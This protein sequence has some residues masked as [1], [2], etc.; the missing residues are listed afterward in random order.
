MIT[1]IEVKNFKA[2]IHETIPL[3][4]LNLL[5]GINGLGKSTIIQ[6]LLLL[7]Q[8]FN[9]GLI[10]NKGILLNGD[11]I[12]LGRANDILNIHSDEKQLSFKIEFDGNITADFIFNYEQDNDFLALSEKI[13]DP[14]PFID[15]ALF[16]PSF[17]YLSAERISPKSAYSTSLFEVDQNRGLGIHGEYTPHFLAQKQREKVS[18]RFLLHPNAN[19]DD[20]LT[21]VIFWAKEIA[22]GISLSAS[23]LPQVEASRIAYQ[24]EQGTSMTPEFSPANI[25]FGVTY[26]LPVLTSILSSRSGDL[27]I[28]ENPESHLHPS[29]QS[30]LGELFFRAALSGVQI[31]VETHS[32]HFLNGVRLA[33]KRA[34]SHSDLINILFFQRS[35]KADKHS[36][37]I[38][39][40][41]ID[42]SGNIESWPDGF[43]DQSLN[44]LNL[45]LGL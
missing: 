16:T 28:I 13:K 44:D 9:K 23:Y 33:V 39:Y 35:K 8:S 4:Q 24:Y 6:I 40:P 41:K 38:V 37:E 20:L 42:N 5:T 26:V 11:L 32:D 34:E 45:L 22:P 29:G 36:T 21:Q 2:F 31:L 43:F 17:K 14:S 1:K 3:S 30:R 15:A 25:G 18:S 7:R 27:I 10:P 12:N 19:S